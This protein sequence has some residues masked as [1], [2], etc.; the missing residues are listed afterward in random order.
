MK[1]RVT[2]I[3]L[4]ED[5]FFSTVPKNTL[6]AKSAALIWIKT[7]LF[8]RLATKWIAQRAAAESERYLSASASPDAIIARLI[9]R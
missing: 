6:N 4:P 7:G 5:R 3:L 8:R 9:A 2:G 1:K